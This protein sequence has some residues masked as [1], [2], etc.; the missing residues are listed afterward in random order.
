MDPNNC[1]CAAGGTCSC[2]DSYKCKDCKCT[3][4][5]KS[6]CC[7]AHCGKCNQDCQCEKRCDT[8]SCC[9]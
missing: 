2:G 3:S 4:C 6:H 5:K 9:K 1:N 8:C 7:P